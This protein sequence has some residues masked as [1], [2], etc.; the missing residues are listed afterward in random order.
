MRDHDYSAMGDGAAASAQ[1]RGDPVHDERVPFGGLDAFAEIHARLTKIEREHAAMKEQ[2]Q[3]A[4]D[5]G[6]VDFD[7]AQIV[8]V[9]RKY[10]PHD[11]PPPAEVVP[12]RPK[13]DP[14]TGEA[15]Q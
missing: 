3:A 4:K 7:K 15:L 6:D 8:H 12:P 14:F 13:F 2:L 1:M 9:M 5:A 10:F 11:M